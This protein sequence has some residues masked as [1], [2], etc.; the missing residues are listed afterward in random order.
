MAVA[1][2]YGRLATVLVCRLNLVQA[3]KYGM[4]DRLPHEACWVS[5][6]RATVRVWRT[7][8]CSIA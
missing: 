4:G 6:D 7:Q 5:G 2:I 8:H 1:L 3:L